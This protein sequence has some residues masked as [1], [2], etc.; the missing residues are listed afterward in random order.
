MACLP[1]AYEVSC[2]IRTGSP[3]KLLA[4]IHPGRWQA[5]VL[6][7]PLLGAE[8]L[9]GKPPAMWRRQECLPRPEGSQPLVVAEDGGYRPEATCRRPDA[10]CH[11]PDATC[12]RPNATC[13]RPNATCRPPD[14][15][16]HRPDATCRRPDA[17]SH[18]PDATSHRPDA[19]CHRPDA[20]CH[21]SNATRHRLDAT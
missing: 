21:R 1:A 17:T 2:R 16:S 19:T 12:H 20:T 11:Q 10:T 15:T 9:A 7:P 8:D 4:F 6:V 13:R 18:R 3:R 14:A 5:V